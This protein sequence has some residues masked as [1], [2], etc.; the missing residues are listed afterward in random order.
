MFYAVR[1]MIEHTMNHVL[2]KSKGFSYQFPNM[3][4]N[5]FDADVLKLDGGIIEITVYYCFGIRSCDVTLNLSN[6]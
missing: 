3:I 4:I 6:T 1:I 2:L 5:V